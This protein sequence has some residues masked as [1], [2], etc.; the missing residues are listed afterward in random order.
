MRNILIST[1]ECGDFIKPPLQF[2]RIGM[3]REAYL[4]KDD[5]LAIP[6]SNF[7]EITRRSL[8]RVAKGRPS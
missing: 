1:I 6:V 7:R 8:Q 2:A 4:G 3:Y 5:F